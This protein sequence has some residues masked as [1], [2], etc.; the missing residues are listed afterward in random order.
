MAKTIYV[1]ILCPAMR[2]DHQKLDSYSIVFAI[3]FFNGLFFEHWL[4]KLFK[5]ICNMYIFCPLH[6]LSYCSKIFKLPCHIILYISKRVSPFKMNQVISRNFAKFSCINIIWCNVF[7]VHTNHQIH[8]CI[9][10]QKLFFG[11]RDLLL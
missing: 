9:L 3:G 1:C 5:N 7:L 8:C 4:K 10:L 6:T 11:S 2:C